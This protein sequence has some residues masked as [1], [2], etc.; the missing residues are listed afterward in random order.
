MK[1]RGNSTHRPTPD[2]SRYWLASTYEQK[3][4]Q[5]LEPDN[6]DK[7][8]LRLWFREQCDPYKDKVLPEAP[9][10]LVLELSRRYITLYEMITWKDFDFAG[11]GGE[12]TVAET[13]RSLAK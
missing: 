8:F 5:G 1:K 2:L 10:D 6:I 13:L 3:V 7:E 12:E 11:V 9:R 4:A